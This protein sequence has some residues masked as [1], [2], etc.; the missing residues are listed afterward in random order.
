MNTQQ[1]LTEDQLARLDAAQ[2]AGEP[3][4][5]DIRELVFNQLELDKNAPPLEGLLFQAARN[6]GKT[7]EQLTDEVFRRYGLDPAS[8]INYN[9]QD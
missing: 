4:P 6:L 7:E 1:P 3:V 2:A 8:I 9:V 5:A